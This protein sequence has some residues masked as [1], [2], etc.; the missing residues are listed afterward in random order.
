[1]PVARDV[2]VDARYFVDTQ[3]VCFRITDAISLEQIFTIADE[4]GR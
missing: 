4:Y 3:V 1:M 2:D